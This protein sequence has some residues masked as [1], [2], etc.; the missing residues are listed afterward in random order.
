MAT[1]APIRQ[2]VGIDVSKKELSV[3]FSN[4][5]QGQRV[6]IRSTKTFP[7]TVAGFKK[8]DGWVRSQRRDANVPFCILMEATGVY[9]EEAAYFLK[10]QGWDVSV[11]L[12]NKTKAFAKSL[13][14]KSKTDA[15][16]AKTLAQMALERSLPVWEPFSPKMLAIKRLCRERVTLQ[17]HKTAAKNQLHAKEHAH[18]TDKSSIRR[19]RELIK[20][21]VKQIKQVEQA[22]EGEVGKDPELKAKVEAVCTLKGVGLI[23]AATVIAE[24]NGFALFRNKAQ[25]V[26]YAGYDVVENSSGSSIRGKTRISKKGNS[27]LRRAMH[28]PALGAI[29]YIPEMKA[30]YERVFDRTKIKM[31]GAVAVQRKLL[32]LIY[33]LFKKGVAYD[34]DYHRKVQ[35]AGVPIPINKAGHGVPA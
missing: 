9:Y 13:D 11:L 33:T 28:F 2:S 32:V 4:M 10:A 35:P 3:C 27:Y 1:S 14:F 30:L 24:T 20:F 25:L 5:E 16:D 31:K 21:L 22:I 34:P 12:P 29:K 26:S 17:G 6:R 15:I 8:L 19:S 23:T 18:Q 7:N